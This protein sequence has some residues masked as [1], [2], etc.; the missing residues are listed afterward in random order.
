MGRR[1]ISVASS[2]W[3]LAGVPTPTVPRQDYLKTTLL[4]GVLSQTPIAEAFRNSYLN[5]PRSR[6]TSFANWLDNSDYTDYVGEIVGTLTAGDNIDT[7][8]IAD[9]IT[10]TEVGGVIEVQGASVGM[11]QFWFWAD[12][13]VCANHPEFVGTDY[14]VDMDEGDN[15]IYVTFEDESTFD[16]T[17]ADFQ[18][19]SRYLYVS[20]REVLPASTGSEDISA[21]VI[22]DEEADF[23]ITGY[24]LIDTDTTT[25]T[26]TLTVTTDIDITYSDATPPSSSSSSTSSSEDWD[27]VHKTYEKWVTVS[28]DANGMV[29]NRMRLYTHITATVTEDVDVSVV[30]EDIGGGVIKTTTTTV[31]TEVIT[32]EYSYEIG[33]QEHTYVT[34][35]PVQVFIYRENTGNSTLDD[36]FH[37]P[38]GMTGFYPFI[39]FRLNNLDVKDTYP[40]LYAVAKKA[41]RRSSKL[42][43]DDIRE[44]L[45]TT[46]N[47]EGETIPNASLGDMDYVYLLYGVALNTVEKAGVKYIYKFFESLMGG[48]TSTHY[49]A[50]KA[51]HDAANDNWDAWEAYIA[52][53]TGS[54]TPPT[55]PERMAYPPMPKN[56]LNLSSTETSMNYNMQLEWNFISYETG[57]GYLDEPN[58]PARDWWIT[59][60]TAET[61]YEA[62]IGS[63][64]GYS[65]NLLK[66]CK[67]HINHQIN[68]TTWERLVVRGLL[69]T[70]MIYGGRAVRLTSDDALEVPFG[71]DDYEESGLIIPMHRQI[72]KETGMIAGTQ[73]CTCNTYL[74]IN[75]YHVQKVKW[76][77]T[78]WFKFILIVAIV[79]VTIVFPPAGGL[80][81]PAAEVGAYIGLTGVPAIIAGTILNYIAALIVI[82]TVGHYATKWFG[83]DVGLI[84]EFITTVMVAVA[85]G[86][87]SSEGLFSSLMRPENLV[88]MTTSAINTYSKH[89]MLGAEELSQQLLEFQDELKTKLNEIEKM[90]QDILGGANGVLTPEQI[91][92][93]ILDRPESLN[94]FLERTTMTGDDL[95]NLSLTLIEKFPEITTN[96]DLPKL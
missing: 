7:D 67:F 4:T 37:I 10:P 72:V 70:N 33:I 88:F 28:S 27:E 85:T 13:W 36:M 17:P 86:G 58:H 21:T 76:Y 57:S 52:S 54:G 95:Y 73:L 45:I 71:D 30:N 29:A 80:L 44:Q 25:H 42:K 63:E 60:E 55:P 31:T 12:Q 79:I 1:I 59:K 41:V 62:S 93:A 35:K 82:S 56:V 47:E 40:D 46:Q 39:P 49:D 22:V 53:W 68:E 89:L 9:E 5:G 19:D 87:I 38:D 78:T 74:V 15:K 20:Y 11:A 32:Y 69:H 61:F 66:L 50:W 83:K 24:T 94:M 6:M 96:L 18:K 64:G 23:P 43:Y 8:A 81:G 90:T 65:N 3:N 48:M 92:K 34:W 26:E 16:F 14:D 84:A 51:T 2:A 77:Q 91:T 75:C